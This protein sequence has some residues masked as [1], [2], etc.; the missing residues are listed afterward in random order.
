MA[1]KALPS[2]ADLEAPKSE[3][4]SRYDMS[5]KRCHLWIFGPPNS[6]KSTWWKTK[7]SEGLRLFMGPYNNDWTGFNPLSFDGIVFD[8]FKG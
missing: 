3:W 2:A 6:G 8:G 1:F 5:Q 4:F 7:K